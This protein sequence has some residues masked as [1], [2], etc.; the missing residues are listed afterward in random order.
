MKW[1]SLLVV[2]LAGC[3]SAL[4]APPPGS[5]WETA[6]RLPGSDQVFRI[7]DEVDPTGHIGTNSGFPAADAL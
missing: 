6:Y 1:A 2:A 5:A 4:L 3:R 7:S